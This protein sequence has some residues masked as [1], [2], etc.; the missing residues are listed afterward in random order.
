MLMTSMR[1]CSILTHKFLLLHLEIPLQDCCSSLNKWLL[2]YLMQKESIEVAMCWKIWLT[3]VEI[4]IS[5][6]WSSCISTEGNQM[7]W[8]SHT[9][10][11]D[12]LCTLAYRMLCL[13]MMLMTNFPICLK[14]THILSS[15][16]SQHNLDKESSTFS[17]ISSLSQK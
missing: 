4:K 14:S 5:L 16:I 13:D 7:E 6:I 10:L 1:I 12:L 17:N 2:S 8:S 3:C 15:T 9:Y 11:L